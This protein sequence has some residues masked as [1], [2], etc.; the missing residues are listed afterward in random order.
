MTHKI[1]PNNF[2]G[3]FHS[4][5]GFTLKSVNEPPSELPGPSPP[6]P[7]MKQQHFFPEEAGLKD[8][9]TLNLSKSLT[10]SFFP[11][12]LVLWGADFVANT[13]RDFSKVSQ[14]LYF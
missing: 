11:G 14:F 4:L 7:M 9:D 1:I 5:S 6:D 12:K 13:I 3:H 8:G 2:A 10:S